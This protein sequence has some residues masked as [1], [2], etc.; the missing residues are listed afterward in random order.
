MK[1]LFCLT[2]AVLIISSLLSACFPDIPETTPGTSEP[3]VSTT[4]PDTTTV[5]TTA[6]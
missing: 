3:P 5:P 4:V 1:R 2:L 6:P